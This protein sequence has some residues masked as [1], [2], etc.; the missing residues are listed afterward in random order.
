MWHCPLTVYSTSPGTRYSS[1]LSC[2]PQPDNFPPPP[3][4]VHRPL[5]FTIDSDVGLAN[6]TMATVTSVVVDLIMSLVIVHKN[7]KLIRRPLN[8]VHEV[9]FNAD[10]KAWTGQVLPW[11]MSCDLSTLFSTG[12][13][14]M[15]LDALLT[16]RKFKFGKILIFIYF[17][18]GVSKK[19]MV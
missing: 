11:P 2:H 1:P 12:G 5:S 4:H 17:L 15:L 16:I 14:G 19:I 9:K 10:G 13:R 8:I 3:P 6:L 18:Q 7:K